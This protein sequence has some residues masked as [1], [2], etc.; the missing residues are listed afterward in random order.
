MPN[1]LQGNRWTDRGN[2]QNAQR[3]ITVEIGTEA[4][5]F[6]FWEYINRNF[7]AVLMGEVYIVQSCY[8]YGENDS[9]LG[10]QGSYTMEATV[11]G[12]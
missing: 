5:Q 7:F 3:H 11:S 10:H 4:A 2:I 6:L 8:L 9:L 12:L 1:L